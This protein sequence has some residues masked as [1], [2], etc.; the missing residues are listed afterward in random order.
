MECMS[1]SDGNRAPMAGGG[2]EFHPQMNNI[3]QEDDMARTHQGRG[4]P[5]NLQ[6][7]FPE[8]AKSLSGIDLPKDK[9][10]IRQYAEENGAAEEV[11]SMIDDLPDRD[12]ETMADIMSETGGG[13]EQ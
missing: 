8:L 11:L 1:K 5:E 3:R 13:K 10:G 6:P 2:P 12:Y 9:E 4:N 7:Q